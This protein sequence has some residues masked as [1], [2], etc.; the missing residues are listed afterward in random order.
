[1]NNSDDVIYDVL[2]RVLDEE[3]L[4][5]VPIRH[6]AR[7]I[8]DLGL[9]SLHIARVLALLELALDRDPFGSGQVPITRVQTVGDLCA[10]YAP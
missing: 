6:D 9:R 10:A 4:E 3:S 1:M 2:A 7:L 8:D 5:P